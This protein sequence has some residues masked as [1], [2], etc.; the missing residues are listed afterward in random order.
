MGDP[1]L[2]R[3]WPDLGLLAIVVGLLYLGLRAVGLA[4]WALTDTAL[5]ASHDLHAG[6][7]IRHEDLRLV[8][9]PAQQDTFSGPD[10]LEGLILG[11]DVRRGQALR[12]EQVLRWQVVATADVPNGAKVLASYLGLAW[13]PYESG[14]ELELGDVIGKMAVRPVERGKTVVV[15]DLVPTLGASRQAT[16]PQG[17]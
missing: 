14:A 10:G 8:R 1:W 3:H 5:V 15:D 12:E 9:R 16:L 2:A 6:A 13:S 11:K 4:P 17:P 7:S